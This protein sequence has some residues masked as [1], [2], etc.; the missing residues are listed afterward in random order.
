MA[1]DPYRFPLT[2]GRT[3]GT[4][5]LAHRAL[6]ALM[7]GAFLIALPAFW[8]LGQSGA[9]SA[10]DALGQSAVV[11]FAWA[12]GRELDPDHDASAFVAIPIA[13]AGSLLLH[14]PDFLLLL[15]VLLLCRL[16]NRSVGRM[17]AWGD[18]LVLGLLAAVLVWR[19]YG[20][21]GWTF[22][23]AFAVDGIVRPPRKVHLVGAG[24]IT[25][26]VIP[27]WILRRPA[28]PPPDSAALPGIGWGWAVIA[29][30]L[31]SLPGVLGSVRVVSVGDRDSKPLSGVRIASAQLLITATALLAICLDGT[32][33]I[34]TL[35]PLW[36][37][38]TGTMIVRIFVPFRSRFRVDRLRRS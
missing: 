3:L 33:M 12:L 23:A 11:F 22:A 10:L 34:G 25:A 8:S 9:A 28:L 20:A 2:L 13:M 18:D 31:L 14:P 15:W 26:A 17:S 1:R 4:D 35:S 27:L 6:F 5:L 21:V 24:L 36:A 16:M 7:S 37:A 19:G 29:V 38:V 30:A 32:R